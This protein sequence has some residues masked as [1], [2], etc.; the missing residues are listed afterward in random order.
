MKIYEI[1]SESRLT[2]GL[3]GELINTM[4]KGMAWTLGRGPRQKAAEELARVWS[5]EMIENAGKIKSGTPAQIEK[6]ITDAG[7]DPK[8][9]A[10]AAVRKEGFKAAEDILQSAERKGFVKDIAQGAKNKWQGTVQAFKTA[11][12]VSNWTVRA[13]KYMAYA[14]PAW[15]AYDAWKKFDNSLDELK[16]DLELG[17]IDEQ[18]YKSNL[19]SDWA[20]FIGQVTAAVAG[21][22]LI[23]LGSSRFIEPALKVAFLGRLKA[24]GPWTG[25]LVQLIESA[26]P[27][28]LW[29]WFTFLNSKTGRDLFVDWLTSAGGKVTGIDGLIMWNSDP[30][31]FMTT[32]KGIFSSNTPQAPGNAPQ[33]P[34]GTGQSGQRPQP[35]GPQ[36]GTTKSGIPIYGEYNK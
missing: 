9:A 3:V 6:I 36:V 35:N 32:A 5:K 1:I 14:L 20:V 22:T 27:G 25:G 4:L 2:E 21:T 34:G 16:K 26:T 23:R 15:E 33:A 19:I 24:T 8:L 28:L 10:D 18:T 13:G 11:G 17:D 31:N 12:E 7:L 30:A 29:A